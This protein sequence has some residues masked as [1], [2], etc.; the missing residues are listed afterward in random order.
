MKQGPFFIKDDFVMLLL[1]RGV[2]T[3]V[4]TLNRLNYYRTLVFMGNGNGVIAYGKGR[5]DTP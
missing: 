4:T 2:S 5:S 1:H 3:K